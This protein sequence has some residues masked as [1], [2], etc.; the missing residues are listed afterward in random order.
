V[1]QVV[2]P[3]IR[4]GAGALV[5]A[6]VTV[7]L[8]GSDE[9]GRIA[10]VATDLATEYQDV[11]LPEAGLT[12]GLQPQSLLALPAAASSWY[13]VELRTPHRRESYLIQVP[14]SGVPLALRDLVGAAEIDPDDLPA[15]IVADALTAAA[16]AEAAS[17]LTAADVVATG[18]DA[19][20]TAADRV[21][22]GLDAQ[23][24]AAD[25]VQTG[26]DA[27]ATAGDRVQAGLDST[28]TAADRVQTGL[29]AQATAADRV[30]T[31]LDVA[32]A[33]TQA[34][35]A[36][37]AATLASA[38]AISPVNT[39]VVELGSDYSAL[40]WAAQSAASGA[41]SG[42]YATAAGD[43]TLAAQQASANAVAVVTGGTASLVPAA[44]KIPLAGASGTLDPA[45]IDPLPGSA[46]AALHRSPNAIT[47]LAIYDTSQDS[48]GGAWT[49]RCAHT[50]WYN[51]P[52]SGAWLGAR[53]SE[54]DARLAG[55][56]TGADVV[57]NGVFAA[58]SN[59]TKG[60]GVTITGGQAVFTAV[61]NN[62]GLTAA[63][64]PL[65][66]GARYVCT[67]TLTAYT[68]GGVKILLGTASHSLPINGT[69]T[70]TV[71]GIANGTAL[72]VQAN[73]TSTL[74]LDNVEVRPVTAS[75]SAANDYF[76]LISDGKFYALSRNLLTT[77]ATLATQSQWLTAGTYTLSSTTD[78]SGSVAVSGA[79]TASHTAGTPTSFVV[80]ASGT[81]TFTVTGSVTTA[82]CE[83]GS[84]ASAYSA[85]A[86]TTR[87]SEVFRGQ[88]RAFPRLAGIVVEAGS[89]TL[90]DLTAPACPMW[91]RV[92]KGSLD[93][94]YAVLSA[95]AV[96]SLASVAARNGELWAGQT[97]NSDHCG[98]L[99]LRFIADSVARTVGG[100]W[101][102]G[103][104]LA[105]R[106]AA[107]PLPSAVP[108]AGVALPSV[109]TALAVTLYPEAPQDPVTRLTVP[110][111]AIAGG[112]GVFLIQPSGVVHKSASSAAWVAISLTPTWL[113]A[114]TSANSSWYS[115][116]APA[117]LGASFALA[118]V[119]AASPPDLYLAP[120]P[121]QA[122]GR[123]RLLR[124]SP[125]RAEIKGMVLDAGQVSRSLT[126]SLSSC[127]TSGWQ[128]GDIRRAFLAS[129][130]TLDAITSPELLVNSDCSDGVTGYVNSSGG[131]ATLTS[132]G[133]GTMTLAGTTAGP[134][135]QGGFLQS[136]A[137]QAGRSYRLLEVSDR[138]TSGGNIGLGWYN[139]GTA[140]SFSNISLR[141][142]NLYT[143]LTNHTLCLHFYQ[144]GPGTVNATFDT[145]SF[146]EV[147][148]DRCYKGG[149]ALIFGLL[150]RTPVATGA[151][152]VGWS[153]WSAVNYLREDYSADLDFATGE[154]SLNIWFTV[155]A[156]NATA[157]TL[158]ARAAASG[159]AI[160]LALNSNNTLTGTAYDGTTTLSVSTPL[161]YNS[162]AWVN[163][164]LMYRAGRLAIII[165]GVEVAATVGA[166]LLTLSNADAVLTLGNNFALDAPFPGSLAL[167]RLSATVP[168]AE[169]IAWI[170]AQELA[171]FQPGVQ[172]CLPD[173]GVPVDLAYDPLTDQWALGTTTATSQWRDLTRLATTPVTAGAVSKLAQQAGATLIGRATTTPGVDVTLA[174]Q[175]LRT[176]LARRA[177]EALGRHDQPTLTFDFDTISF[178]ATTTTGAL[179]LTSVA[180][181]VGTPYVGMKI[182]GT[183][184]PTNCTLAGING[185]TYT[186]SAAATANGS[187]IAVGQA[188]FTLPVGYTARAVYAAGTQK[189][190]GATKD[191][192]RLHDGFRETLRFGTSPGAASWVQIHAV[193][194]TL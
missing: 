56:T 29:D 170:Y 38:W 85:N 106:Q 20:A 69:G 76:Q 40:H 162:A 121:P 81:V 8:V 27:Q 94:A 183:G 191:Y 70:Y 10:F 77:T 78:S 105:T 21:Q 23:A 97:G 82:Q 43:A 130:S 88:S 28:A 102:T 193:P 175:D 152:L 159:P 12:L 107:T 79:A 122:I 117:A 111:L 72:S 44:G 144:Y 158:A 146:K 141:A 47:A 128:V 50:S 108:A 58:D 125:S 83:L 148:G 54:D 192:T 160:A 63:V 19:L 52:L 16:D 49:Q 168:T 55:A 189:R 151:Q 103:L 147:D 96:T 71:A 135:F 167:L 74:T 119:A 156:A 132:N 145:I 126:C 182:T 41:L 35:N 13:R 164:V 116:A 86:S 171:L 15:G 42:A 62:A 39:P 14:E 36:T 95:N 91:L 177:E 3:A 143:A 46:L 173:I 17:L 187:T 163:V 9:Q 11:A 113:N 136:M 165:N 87:Y 75:V 31:G 101:Y 179:S 123:A 34:G 188:D 4:D 180:S 5:P 67:L 115:A 155:P 99:K 68:S 140:A 176:A 104:T 51:E 184:I 73:G 133:N 150:S 166:P 66:N 157:G 174:A 24:T 169:Q 25:R 33:T 93:S 138:L 90:Y 65:T 57:I 48:D 26:L 100:T 98:L 80:A 190:E 161:A 139:N 60:T 181:V 186:L 32:T 30:Q 6:T 153:G 131:W 7:R 89:L 194:E 114:W 127:F 172:C 178:T 185:T 64:A 53:I 154:W 59:W 109:V 61:A 2:I 37:T 134:T 112:T 92:A 149:A 124:R 22:T 137:V 142:N 118:S 18:A 110:T 84:V 45:W 129:V 120:A 1:T